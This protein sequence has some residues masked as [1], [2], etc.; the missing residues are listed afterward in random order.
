MPRFAGVPV[1]VP[2]AATV[3][4]PTAKPRFGGEPVDTTTAAPARYD[5]GV[6]GEVNADGSTTPTRLV[7]GSPNPPADSLVPS[8]PTE[9]GT[10]SQALSGVNQGLANGL[11]TPIDLINLIMGGGANAIN[12][13]AGTDL[14]PP[15]KPFLGSKSIGDMMAGAG[16][17]T[18]ESTDPGQ[19][20]VRRIGEEIGGALIPEVGLAGR[21]GRSMVDVA[22][23]L[24]PAAAAG[25]GAAAAEQVAPGNQTAET[26][27]ELVG[28]VVP[29]TAMSM[30]R[31]AAAAVVAPTLEQLQAAKNAAYA[32]ADALGARYTPDAY[33]GLVNKIVS[34]AQADK[35]SVIRHPKSTSWIAELQN[36]PQGYSPTLTELDQIRQQVRRDLVTPAAGN[37]QHDAEAHFGR[38]IIGNIDDL[39]D[40]ATAGQMASGSASDAAAAIQAARAAN[41]TYRKTETIDDTIGHATNQVAATGSGGN[42][43]NK[44]RQGFVGIVDNPK[45]AQ[46]FT[47]PEREAMLEIIMGRRGDDTLRLAGKLSP[48]GNGLMTGL[49]LGAVTSGNPVLVAA[50]IVGAVAKHIADNVTLGR[51]NRLRASIARGGPA[52]LPPFYSPAQ[53]D[54][55]VA[56]AAGAMAGQQHAD[57]RH[58]ELLDAI[59]RGLP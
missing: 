29:S 11:G 15:E 28:G 24:A 50:P 31:R 36:A 19:Q 5:Y 14:H 37:P 49:G 10:A 30:G 4:V 55:F 1:D 27:G 3:P 20:V 58:R 47:D 54:G 40:T 45:K 52:T 32:R 44:I 13:V 46:G 18:P 17:I 41:A 8:T 53:Q 35:I 39:L 59:M 21:A 33:D 22:R 16:A 7:I 43:N 34:D 57:D 9:M 23:G 42:I 12:A 38:Q 6:S 2:A 26:V 48:G 56:E 51:A 25:A